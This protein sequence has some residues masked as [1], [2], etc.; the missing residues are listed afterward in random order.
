MV[1]FA[2]MF[3]LLVDYIK[4]YLQKKRSQGIPLFDLSRYVSDESTSTLSGR[5]L[6]S[7]LPTSASAGLSAPVV[8]STH[9]RSLDRY[10]VCNF[11]FYKTMFLP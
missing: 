2:V 1:F 10:Q 7:R 11:L 6:P 5:H 9:H 4:L 3:V 8:Q